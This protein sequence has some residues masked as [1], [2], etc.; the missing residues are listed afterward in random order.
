MKFSRR[1]IINFVLVVLIV[2]FTYIGNRF[3]VQT[4]YQSQNRISS[5][6]PAAITRLE[7]QTA[8]EALRLERSSS[9]WSI[10]SP[11]Q[12]PA[13]A[14]NIERL[15]D[16][17]NSET[18][19]RLAADELDLGQL[20]L[21]FPRAMIRLDDTQILFG[22]TNNIGERRYTLIGKE[23]FL[24]PDIHLPFISQ[25]LVGLVDRRLLPRELRLNSLRLPDVELTHDDTGNWQTPEPE[26][27]PQDLIAQLI[28]N[29]QGLEAIRVARY[30]RA[31]TPRQ[32][33]VAR[34]EDGS[35]LEFF[36]MS[37][38]P[39]IVI[40]LPKIDLQYHFNADYYYQLIALPVNEN[41]A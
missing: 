24:L 40:A 11:I 8:D 19:S 2:L 27:Y 6:D 4:G 10:T 36:L 9:G 38:E 39:E 28:G 1:W 35:S 12:W 23:V 5:T 29:W 15:L 34:L 18:D 7:I 32:K 17:L 22:D 37:I 21:Q 31:A 3:D 30:N 14:I 26:S 33:L 41:P 16:I 20:G 25:G 13:N